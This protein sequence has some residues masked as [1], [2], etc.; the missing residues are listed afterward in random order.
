MPLGFHSS[1]SSIIKTIPAICNQKAIGKNE[2]VTRCIM[3]SANVYCFW[4]KLML[5]GKEDLNSIQVNEDF[6]LNSHMIRLSGLN[7][8]NLKRHLAPWFQDISAFVQF[9]GFLIRCR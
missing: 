6:G 4:L 9:V 7:L 8:V 1:Q 5:H 3:S 2:K